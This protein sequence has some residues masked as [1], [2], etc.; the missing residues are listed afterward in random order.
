M[1]IHEETLQADELY[2]SIPRLPRK[3]EIIG[4]CIGITVVIFILVLAAIVLPRRK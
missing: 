3:Q 4:S 1:K 2:Q